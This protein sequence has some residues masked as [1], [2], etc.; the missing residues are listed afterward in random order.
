MP[1]LWAA[2]SAAPSSAEVFPDKACNISGLSGITSVKSPSDCMPRAASDR[3]DARF[4]S[5]TSITQFLLLIKASV[6]TIDPSEWI[7]IR[8]QDRVEIGL[9]DRDFRDE[10]SL[11]CIGIT[12]L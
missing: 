7:S 2:E 6:S 10:L 4:S 12:T 8:E 5:C 11:D 1:G 3:P 9:A